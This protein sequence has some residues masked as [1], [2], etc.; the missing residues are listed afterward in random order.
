M[1]NIILLAAIAVSSPAGEKI[2]EVTPP[3]IAGA[4][5]ETRTLEGGMAFRLRFEG[6]GERTIENEEW[7][8]DFGGDFRCWPVAHAQGEYLP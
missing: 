2:C 1:I 8:F 3:A 4:A 7:R 6:E 5:L